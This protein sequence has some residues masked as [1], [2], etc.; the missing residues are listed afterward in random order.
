MTDMGEYEK[1]AR[2]FHDT[3][4]RLAPQFGYATR[5]D[6]KAFDPT[7]PNGLL[8]MAVVKEMNAD[9]RQIRRILCAAIAGPRA[10]MDD[11]EA[12]DCSEVPHIDFLRMTPYQIEQALRARGLN[13]LAKAP[14][15]EQRRS[16]LRSPS[17]RPRVCYCP[18]GKCGAP[19]IMGRQTP[20]IRTGKLP[21]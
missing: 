9:E 19:V 16:L 20:C 1:L 4:E 17:E 18:E 10:Y 11:G 5:E 15:T 6:T 8:M 2:K 21:T 12:S 14:E 7:T 3:Y 13:R